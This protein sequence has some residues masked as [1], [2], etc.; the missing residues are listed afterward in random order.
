MSLAIFETRGSVRSQNCVVAERSWE[1]RA[2]AGEVL[3]QNVGS[4][5]DTRLFEL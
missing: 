4:D 1:E 5:A 3:A 2:A